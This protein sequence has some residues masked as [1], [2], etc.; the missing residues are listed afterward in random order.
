MASGASCLG[1][2]HEL[3][4]HRRRVAALHRELEL[5]GLVDHRLLR[6][7][8]LPPLAPD[9]RL[10][11]RFAGKVERARARRKAFGVR[12]HQPDQIAGTPRRRALIRCAVDIALDATHR[13]ALRLHG[14]APLLDNRPLVLRQ[15]AGHAA[16][17]DSDEDRRGDRA[18]EKAFHRRLLRTRPGATTVTRDRPKL[19]KLGS[20]TAR[21]ISG[22]ETMEMTV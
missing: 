22:S 5:D 10:R 14:G 11:A 6:A 8:E 15:C 1:R 19:Y 16:S 18:G 13:R 3:V 20:I 21:G 9:E 12:A 4:P 17:E 7:E 2:P